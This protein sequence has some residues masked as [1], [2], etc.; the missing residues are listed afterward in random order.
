MIGPN[1]SHINRAK[2]PFLAPNT[3]MSKHQENY[4]QSKYQQLEDTT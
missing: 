3:T 2:V 1:I 4:I